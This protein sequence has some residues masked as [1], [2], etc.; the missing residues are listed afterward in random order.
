MRLVLGLGLP[1]AS[2]GGAGP[3]GATAGLLLEGDMAADPADFLL[4]EG[5][6]ADDASDFLLLEGD[7]V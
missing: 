5:D 7:M 6:M 4:L 3:F 2:S 1:P